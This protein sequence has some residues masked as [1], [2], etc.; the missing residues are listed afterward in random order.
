ML[1]KKSQAA[2]E[3]LM[4]Y[5]WA[6]LIVLIGIGALF[7]LGVFNPSTPSTCNTASP[8]ICQDISITDFGGTDELVIKLAATGM[9][10]ATLTKINIGGKDCP[11]LR[12]NNGDPTCETKTS[13][14]ACVQVP[15]GV[16][17]WVNLAGYANGGRCYPSMF[18]G[19][20]AYGDIS[21]AKESPVKVWCVDATGIGTEGSKISGTFNLV[22]TKQFGVQ[23]SIAGSFSGT[24]EKG[25]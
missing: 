24:M 8:F 13:P 21:K 17:N 18:S 3:F 23:H 20:G 15:G 4:T 12:S 16:C 19:P 14:T 5:G 22:Y 9:D 11:S 7:F 10:S 25:I 2:M 6:I 1:N